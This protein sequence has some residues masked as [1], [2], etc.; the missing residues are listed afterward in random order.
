MDL[1]IEIKTFS[2]ADDISD[3]LLNK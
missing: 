3:M 1:T 2:T